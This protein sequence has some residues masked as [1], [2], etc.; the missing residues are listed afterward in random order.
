MIDINHTALH[1]HAR[2]FQCTSTEARQQVSRASQP[3]GRINIRYEVRSF[4]LLVAP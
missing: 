4:I 2:M 3:T 1:T